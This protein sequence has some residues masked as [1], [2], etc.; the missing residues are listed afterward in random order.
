[1]A[2]GTRQARAVASEPIVTVAVIARRGQEFLSLTGTRSSLSS[3]L[4]SS[5]FSLRPLDPYLPFS[6]R[7]PPLIARGYI[8][9]VRRAKLAALTLLKQSI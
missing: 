8:K 4:S 6:H 7:K 9:P 3:L 2:R 5:F 1:M